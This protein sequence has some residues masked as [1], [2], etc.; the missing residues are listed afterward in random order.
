MSRILTIPQQQGSMTDKEYDHLPDN[1]RYVA[2]QVPYSRVERMPT[3]MLYELKT[4]VIR[5]NTAIQPRRD[6]WGW[7]PV[8]TDASTPWSANRSHC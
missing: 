5:Q 7:S 4:R 1:P 2:N 3:G 8:Y 6:L